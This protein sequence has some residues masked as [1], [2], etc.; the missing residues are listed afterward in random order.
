MRNSSSRPLRVAV[1][2]A[3]LFLLVTL[4]ASA[5]AK[6]PELRSEFKVFDLTPAFIEQGA[7][8]DDLLVYR[9]GGIV[10]L[11]GTTGD[12]VKATDAVEIATV[13]GYERVAN[14]IR[15]VDRP[16]ADAEIAARGKRR[17]D[18]ESALHGCRFH[19]ESTNGVVRVGGTVRS[20][21]QKELAVQVLRKIPGA[22]SVHWN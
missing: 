4:G 12:A 16:A 3:A 2:A 5:K 1:C 11:R 14:L 7:D 17:L 9:V 22:K 6:V 8:I 10:V 13:L 21:G 20:E 18:L 15:V 19:V